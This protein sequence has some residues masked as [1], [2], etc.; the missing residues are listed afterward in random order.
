[1]ARPKEFSRSEAIEKAMLAFWQYGY[2]QTSMQIL[3]DAMSMSRS[4]I[5][6][7]FESKEALF[8]LAIDRYAEKKMTKRNTDLEHLKGSGR[9]RIQAVFDILIYDLHNQS[10]P[11]GCMLTDTLSE[12]PEIDKSIADFISQNFSEIQGMY[13]DLIRLGKTDG[14]IQSTIPDEQLARMVFNLHESTI[15]LSTIDFDGSSQKQV[16]RDFLQ[17]IA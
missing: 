17:L 14:S 12:I 2:S 5:Y 16:I 11:D 3:T 9:D 7:E 1:M 8:T 4:S 15:I 10:L 13:Q 6:S